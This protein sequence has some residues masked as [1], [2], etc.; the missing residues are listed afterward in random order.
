[1]KV[2]LQ[3]FTLSTL[4]LSL[5]T[6]LAVTGFSESANAQR[7]G[8]RYGTSANIPS[9]NFDVFLEKEDGTPITDDED[10]VNLGV[11]KNAIEIIN[12]G[13]QIL[14]NVFTNGLELNS[15]AAVAGFDNFE[16]GKFLANFSAELNNDN[17]IIYQIFFGDDYKKPKQFLKFA[18]V[19]VPFNVSSRPDDIEN[20][21]VNDLEFILN[22]SK[23][24][25]FDVTG[26]NN[27]VDEP[28]VGVLGKAIDLSI[29]FQGED[30]DNLVDND[31][32][33]IQK[34]DSPPSTSIPEPT[35]T[36]ATLFALGCAGKFLRKTKKSKV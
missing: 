8:G 21:L 33:K 23:E 24:G 2:S 11:F 22:D 25:T 19:D 4:T 34:F 36:L 29:E 9:L 17:K 13:D 6:A 12:D 1:M 26:S 7:K 15:G 32:L 18:P 28:K 10:D 16:D 5:A 30:P 3:K 20:P 27:L 14:T 31:F 35:T